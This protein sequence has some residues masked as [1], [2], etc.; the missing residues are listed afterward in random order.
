MK[1]KTTI[2]RALAFDLVIEEFEVLD[3]FGAR[4]CYIATVYWRNRHT[5]VR[6]HIRRSRLPETIATLRR[7]IAR[8][9]IRALRRLAA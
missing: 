1:M 3:R 8:D 5:K 2:I 9:G 6:Y 4:L 7:E